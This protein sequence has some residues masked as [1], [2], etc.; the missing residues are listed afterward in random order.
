MR[1]ATKSSAATTATGVGLA[2]TAHADTPVNLPVTDSIRA[3][4]LQVGATMKGFAVLDFT[5]L[6]AGLTYYTYD[7]DTPTYRAG[8]RLQPS[9]LGLAREVVPADR[10][11]NVSRAVCDGKPD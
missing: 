5:G 6:E 2:G 10:A 7:P 8:A 3:Q 4:L 9:A 1:L 11:V